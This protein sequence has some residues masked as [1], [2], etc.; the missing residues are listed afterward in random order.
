MATKSDISVYKNPYGAWVCS[1]I[2]DGGDY[3]KQVYYFYTSAQAV[4]LFLDFLKEA[5]YD[6]E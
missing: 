2:S 4:R 1:Y 3:V 6:K 5:G